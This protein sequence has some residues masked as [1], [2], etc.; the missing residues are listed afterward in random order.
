MAY[1]PKVIEIAAK[2]LN[3]RKA[4]NKLIADKRHAEICKKIPK[5]GKLELELANTMTD[6][7][8]AI[9]EKN[10]NSKE[11]VQRAVVRNQ[12]IQADMKRLL[13]DNGY[14]RDYMDPVYTCSKC[15]DSGF[16]DEGRCECFLKI[17][18]TVAA[19]EFNKNSLLEL[20]SFDEFKLSYYPDDDGTR[21]KKSSRASMAENFKK[22]KDFAENFNGKGKGLFIAGKTGQGK[23]HLS[24]SIA[25]ELLGRGF[26]VMYNST[27]S[28]LAALEKESFG[29]S[30]TDLLPLLTSCDLLILDDLGTEYR[31]ERYPTFLYEIID[32]RQ[33]RDLPMI[34]NTN[35]DLKEE[36]NERYQGKLCSRLLSME[37]L[38]FCGGDNRFQK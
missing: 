28:I 36:L 3:E 4:E 31:S 13:E 35:I 9:A 24:L 26:S 29:R 34:I 17:I 5:Y 27:P 30:D 32:T 38:I 1:D 15:R 10:E 33:S 37:I 18:K 20:R 11:I 6:S 22:C 12:E 14:A 7:F 23:T 25:N 8:R 16:T 2:R 19:E 21:I